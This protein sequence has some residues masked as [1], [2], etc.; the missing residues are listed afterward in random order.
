MRHYEPFIRQ[1]FD[2]LHNEMDA[3]Q[4]SVH[5]ELA[6]KGIQKGIDYGEKCFYV[7]DIKVNG[8]FLNTSQVV[9]LCREFSLE[10]TP[11]LR[12][13]VTLRDALLMNETFKSKV[14]PSIEGDNFAE[15]FVIKPIEPAYFGDG[16][17]AIKQKS[18]KFEE[19]GGNKVKVRQPVKPLCKIDIAIVNDV[20][21]YITENRLRNVLSKEDRPS[22]K[23]FG[24]VAGKLLQDALEDF[25]KDR[26]LKV[27]DIAQEYT[28]VSKE[29]M[30]I[31]CAL[32]RG[33]NGQTWVQICEG[34]F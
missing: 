17:I 32:T 8:T 2:K 6:G 1:L 13:E 10:H 25:E 4:V 27:K 29:C 14:K 21:F 20:S 23:E 11:V 28:R 24:K 22:H 15:G 12:E 31:A 30:K 3:T 7:F 18:K 16:R 5:G 9:G 33:E 26:D 19:I 34:E